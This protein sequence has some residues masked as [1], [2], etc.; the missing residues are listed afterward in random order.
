[1]VPRLKSFTGGSRKPSCSTS[2]ACAE[3]PPGTMPPMSGQCPVFCSQ[4]KCSP[5]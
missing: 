3:N 2:V 4:Q 5:R 1:M